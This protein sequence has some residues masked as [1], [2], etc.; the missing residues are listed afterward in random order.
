[1]VAA[2]DREVQNIGTKTQAEVDKMKAEYESK[3]ATLDADRTRVFGG[4][5]A[6]VS[7]LKETAKSGLYQLK[8]DVFQNDGNAHLRYTLAESLNPKMA[9]RLMHSGPGTFW[10]NMEGKGFNLMMPAA[11]AEQR[12]AEWVCARRLRLGAPC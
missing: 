9:L 7:K 8:M 3:S 10:T 5:Q 1:M 11:T 12:P 2:I 4:A 6:E